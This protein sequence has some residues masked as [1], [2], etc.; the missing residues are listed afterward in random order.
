MD[1]ISWDAGGKL[2]AG[3]DSGE[4]GGLAGSG[5]GHTISFGGDTGGE[6]G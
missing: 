4:R 2:R 3:G 5:T 1:G 6:L